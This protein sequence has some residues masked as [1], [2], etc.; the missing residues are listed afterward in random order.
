MT[1]VLV[2]DDE[3]AIREVIAVTLRK[4]GYDVFTATNGAEGLELARKRLPGLII[5]DVRMVLVDGY[6]VLAAI[7]NN[8][9]TASIPFILATSISSIERMRQGMELGADDFLPK[10]FTPSQLL[11]AVK[12]RLEKHV[13]LIRQAETKLAL[14]REHLS[15]A[16]PHELRTPLN[17]ILG[18]ADILRKQFTDLEP[19]EVAQM[20]ERIYKNGKRLNR[21]IENFL[22]YAQIEIVKMDYQ[23][24]EQ[25]RKNRAGNTEQIVDT[26]V[27]QRAYEAERTG[28]LTLHL[29]RGGVAMSAEY[30]SKVVE[31]L[32]DNAIRYSKK[33]SPLEVESE[34]RGNEFVLRIRDQGRGMSSEQLHSIGA[35]MQFD[36]KVYEQQGSGLGLTVAMRLTE[37]HG[38]FLKLESEYEKGTTVTVTLPVSPDEGPP[39]EENQ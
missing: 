35:Y 33:G 16:L 24:I 3:M 12:A 5:C 6:E 9:S 26:A 38:G 11:A 21:L 27:C 17:G 29:S 13:I 2:I 32:F 1:K 39:L 36:R 30:F 25:L 20:A 7:R 31:E 10:P 8:P 28:D 19:R 34:V 15:T 14:L 22:I 4:S 18:Y 37:I 23:K